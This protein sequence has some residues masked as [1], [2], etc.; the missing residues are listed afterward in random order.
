MRIGRYILS[1]GFVLIIFVFGGYS[2]LKPDIE[3]SGFENRTL[4]QVP[5]AN[6]EKLKDGSLFREFETYFSD[7]FVARDSWLEGYTRI[8]LGLGKT[9]I[10]G[11]HVTADKWI[12]NEPVGVASQEPI[13]EA[14]NALNHFGEKL[15]EK[16][17]PLYYFPLPSKATVITDL[18]PSYFP[19]DKG[20]WNKEYLLSQL[21]KSK[22][23]AVDVRDKF[24]ES[25]SEEEIFKLYFKTDHHWN[26][27]GAFRGYQIVINTLASQYPGEVEMAFT[28]DEMDQSCVNDREFAG[29]WNKQ[30]YLLVE[31]HGDKICYL[32]PKRNSI[33]EELD[34]YNGPI[35]EENHVELH[36]VYATALNE[37]DQLSPVSY[38]R[39]YTFDYPEIN[40]I[41]GQ[42]PN[43][44]SVL[45][46]KDSYTNPIT[47]HLAH[48][49]KHT[50]IY[51]IRHNE[52]I[53]V[54]DFVTQN[55]FDIVV[56]MYN[57]RNLSG[58]M[59]GFE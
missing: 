36:E 23:T 13:D 25:L 45:I 58:D 29:S 8:Q 38:A 26:I 16:G 37:E 3:T 27:F 31:G 44:L 35:N 20:E 4:A 40:V 51:D 41:N 46:L 5:D 39:S 59:F 15:K 19:E 56:V 21:D 50:T 18:L 1:M 28:L 6:W 43:D 14:A 22:V 9:F 52:D 48:Q 24:E 17:I 2:L 49:F 30:L 12:I 53:S 55:D 57:D 10:E 33:A 34:I 54:F 32:L 47:Y 7:Q 11:Y 42:A